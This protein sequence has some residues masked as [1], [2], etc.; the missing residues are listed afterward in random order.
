MLSALVAHSVNVEGDVS[1]ADVAHVHRSGPCE[2]VPCQSSGYQRRVQVIVSASYALHYWSECEDSLTPPLIV[3][4]LPGT[5]SNVRLLSS[6]RFT[7]SYTMNS[8]SPYCLLQRGIQA[9][10][11]GDRPYDICTA[12]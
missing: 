8:T 11:I 5:R 10:R 3:C 7:W 6:L 4:V 9:E 1:R 12:C 2:R